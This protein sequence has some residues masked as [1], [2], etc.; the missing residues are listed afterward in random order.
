MGGTLSTALAVVACIAAAFVVRAT[1]AVWVRQEVMSDKLNHQGETIKHLIDA[2]GVMGRTTAKA[3][4][5]WWNGERF[6]DFRPY[7]ENGASI[8]KGQSPN[9]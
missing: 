1:L 5:Q 7:D 2:M 3:D 4:V 9:Q 8:P 6:V